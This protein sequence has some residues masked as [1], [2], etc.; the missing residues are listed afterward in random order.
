MK[1]FKNKNK[2]EVLK[3]NNQSNNSE[4][5]LIKIDGKLKEKTLANLK[6]NFL[7]EG[8]HIKNGGVSSPKTM[9]SLISS[10]AGSVGLAGAASGQ[11]FMATANP[12]TL[13]QIGNGVGSAVMGAGGIVGQ[14][15]FIAVGGALMPVVA[16]L[17]AFQAISTISILNQFEGVNKKLDKI[18]ETVS[19]ILVRNEMD[20][21]G[22]ILSAFTRIEELESEYETCNQFT[23]S[24]I[25]R[26]AVLENEVNPL[27][28]RYEL[29]Y[30]GKDIN[31]NMKS[32]DIKQKN[33]DAAMAV[34]TSIL[35]M[36]IDLLKMKLNVQENPGF[37]EKAANNFVNKI[38]KYQNFYKSVENDSGELKIASNDLKNAVNEMNWWQK[39]MPEWLFGKREERK[40]FE[41]KSIDFES[42]SIKHNQDFNEILSTSNSISDAIQTGIEQSVNKVNLIYWRDELGEHSYYTED[43]PIE[44]KSV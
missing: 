9:L 21:V 10:G 19:N 33:F 1:T 25:V 26:L 29:L 13:M 31:M 38:E 12:A 23:P 8:D 14:A 4:L 40:D 39:N 30:E 2:V 5:A 41:T 17:I 16:P 37:M 36:R 44:F 43:L 27:Y 34:I 22:R 7:I 15:P 11:L 32:K 24:M 35:D 3:L 28:H 18:Q 6:L 20:S 42:E